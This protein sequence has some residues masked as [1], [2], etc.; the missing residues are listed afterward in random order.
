MKAAQSSQTQC[1]LPTA[2]F[3][4]FLQLSSPIHH[5]PRRVKPTHPNTHSTRKTFELDQTKALA[6]TQTRKTLAL[7]K[8][9]FLCYSGSVHPL[10]KFD[11]N[12]PITTMFSPMLAFVNSKSVDAKLEAFTYQKSF[13][14][15]STFLRSVR[16][17]QFIS[18]V[19]RI[20]HKASFSVCQAL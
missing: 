7:D 18:F 4:T 9:W 6:S 14:L 3:N 11:F 20:L 16:L 12:N 8:A 17:P 5:T 19:K 10:R 13:A 15:S 2:T 1:K